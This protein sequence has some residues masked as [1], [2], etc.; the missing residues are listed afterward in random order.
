MNEKQEEKEV[1]IENTCTYL[2]AVDELCTGLGIR[3][4]HIY[5]RKEVNRRCIPVELDIF[6]RDPLF[7]GG[8]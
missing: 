8:I 7:S 5:R 2:F 6:R 3:R 4:T 1:F